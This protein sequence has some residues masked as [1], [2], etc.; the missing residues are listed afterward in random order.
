MG[1]TQLLL[2]I[3]GVIV[4]GVAVAAGINLF[5]RS[6]AEMNRDQI[7]SD[8]TSLSAGAQAYYKKQVQFGGGGGSYEGW[9]LPGFY[10]RYVGNRIRVR[11]QA[12]RDRLILI[13]IGSELGINNRTK[14]KV[15]FIVRPNNV[16]VRI[17]N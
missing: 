16:V 15:K 13:G 14:V 4:V 10:K 12:W 7:I 6:S 17:L 9:T 5:Q 11:V 2:V 1:Q 8:L 3:L